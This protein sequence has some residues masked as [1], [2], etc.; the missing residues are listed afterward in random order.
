[1]KV[2]HLDKLIKRCAKELAFRKALQ[3]L[4]LSLPWSLVSFAV[5][6]LLLP[7]GPAWLAAIYLLVPILIPILWAAM[8]YRKGLDLE[9]AASALDKAAGESD[10]F[11]SAF[12]FQKEARDTVDVSKGAPAAP[13]QLAAYAVP[14]RLAAY[15]VPDRMAA[16]AASIMKQLTIARAEERAAEVWKSPM[17]RPEPRSMSCTPAIIGL[18]LFLS[19]FLA[20]ETGNPLLVHNNMKPGTSRYVTESTSP[21][22]AMT[23]QR[24]TMKKALHVLAD[25]LTKKEKDHT[26]LLEKPKEQP[27]KDQKQGAPEKHGRMIQKPISERIMAAKS[28]HY[29]RVAEIMNDLSTKKTFKAKG[30]F[31]HG[32]DDMVRYLDSKVLRGKNLSGKKLEDMAE[33]VDDLS[34]RMSELAASR[35][36][37]QAMDPIGMTHTGGFS[38]EIQGLLRRSLAE[39]LRHYASTLRARAEQIS[40]EQSRYKKALAMARMGRPK[41]T[42]RTGLHSDAPADGPM[43]MD[44]NPSPDVSIAPMKP[45]ENIEPNNMKG[46]GTT[47]GAKGAGAGK[48]PRAKPQEIG[49]AGEY[50]YL[51]VKARVGQGKSCFEL[52]KGTAPGDAEEIDSEAFK[53]LVQTSSSKAEKT[54]E[55][56]PIPEDLKE[57]IKGYFKALSPQDRPDG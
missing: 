7:L 24:R 18:T 50:D 3:A 10:L 20:G 4:K 12:E 27:P 5:S 49:K 47:P 2:H 6:L 51:K 55:Q 30:K 19:V 28:E 41:K 1:M 14:D 16:S 42:R 31:D 29:F 26:S 25:L 48:G 44:K 53:G 45:P 33:K 46:N 37:R 52:L 11:S 32:V 43:A 22:P 13:E 57:I 21:L 34:Q 17:P 54:M 9:S 38:N 36:G 23:P 56:E 8:A 39:F 15:A 40:R 35:E